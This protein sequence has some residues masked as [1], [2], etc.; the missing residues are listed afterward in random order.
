MLRAQRALGIYLD[1]FW[2]PSRENL[3]D[4]PSRAHLGRTYCLPP[5]V[6]ALV[7]ERFRPALQ[8]FAVG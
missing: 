4:A 3:A 8:L 1:V 7:R 5:W 6:A 2:V